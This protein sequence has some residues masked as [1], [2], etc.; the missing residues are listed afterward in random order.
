MFLELL[1]WTE[2]QTM[3]ITLIGYRAT[4]KSTVGR[5]LATRL[6]WDFVDTD[7]EIER[8]AGKSIS[9]IFFEEGEPAFR[10]LEREQIELALTQPQ[11]VV[12]S[13][14]GAVLNVESRLNMK[15]SGPVIWLKAEVETIVNRLL[16]DQSSEESRPSLTGGGMLAEVAQVLKDREP[17]YAEIAT[18]S[19][20]TDNRTTAE[21]VNAILESQPIRGV[22]Q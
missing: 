11:S 19:I 7:R 3:A 9:A 17:I 16:A 21:I 8:V 2:K 4:G 22:I 20:D 15:E 18:V 10:H 1:Y 14:G 13:G 12:S 6:G 5:E